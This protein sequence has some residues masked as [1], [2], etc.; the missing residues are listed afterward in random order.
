MEYVLSNGEVNEV[1]EVQNLHITLAVVDSS[2]SNITGF[3]YSELSHKL[4][5][6]NYSISYM[7][8]K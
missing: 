1:Y 8:A 5:K 6:K 3:F 2:F 7:N 4:D